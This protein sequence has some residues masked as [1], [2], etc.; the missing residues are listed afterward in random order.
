MTTPVISGDGI[1]F[2]LFL[3]AANVDRSVAF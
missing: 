1:F 2:P 3:D